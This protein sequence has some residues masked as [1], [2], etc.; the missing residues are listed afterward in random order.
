[1]ALTDLKLVKKRRSVLEYTPIGTKAKT[2][3]EAL[4]DF[5][6]K[7]DILKIV[8]QAELTDSTTHEVFGQTVMVRGGGDEP[9]RIDF[10]QMKANM[11]EFGERLRCRLDNAKGPVDK[12]IN[13]LDSA[14]RDAREAAEAN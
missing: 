9:G 5:T 14:A 13:C 7:F 11:D 3:F 4:K 6:M 8:Y 12:Q 1:M 10:D 2:G